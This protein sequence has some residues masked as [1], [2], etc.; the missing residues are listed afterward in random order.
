MEERKNVSEFVL[1]GLTQSIQG[2]GI[3]FVVFLLIYIATMVGNLLIVLTVVLSPTLDSP[4]YFF[5]GYL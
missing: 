3:L 1:L 2:Q 4:M 5:L